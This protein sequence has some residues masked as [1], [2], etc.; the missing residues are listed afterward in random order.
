MPS[1]FTDTFKDRRKKIT[2]AYMA[3]K[4]GLVAGPSFQDFN[5]LYYHNKHVEGWDEEV[6][7]INVVYKE[8]P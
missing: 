1:E 6:K 3:A 7:T 2:N 5:N 8:E 4:T